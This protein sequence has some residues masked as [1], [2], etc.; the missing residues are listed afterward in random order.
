MIINFHLFSI[1]IHK[2][3][4]FIY[5]IFQCLISFVSLISTKGLNILIGLLI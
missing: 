5:N 3:N 1:C 4:L 2:I